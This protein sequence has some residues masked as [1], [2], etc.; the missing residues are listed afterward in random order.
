MARIAFLCKLA[1]RLLDYGTFRD[2]RAAGLQIQ[3]ATK[4]RI[5]A[6]IS[7]ACVSSAKWPVSKKRTTAPGMSRLT[8]P[9]PGGRKNGWFWPPPARGG[10]LAG[11]KRPRREGERR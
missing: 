10:G 11:G 9:A 3:D 1:A 4:S 2:E 6:A 5:A 7:S 8:A